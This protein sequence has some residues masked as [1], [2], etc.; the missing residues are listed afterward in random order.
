MQCSQLETD[1]PHITQVD[2]WET[3]MQYDATLH[4]HYS[5]PSALSPT[6]FIQPT[7]TTQISQI[8]AFLSQAQCN[9]AVKADRHTL[10]VGANAIHNGITIRSATKESDYTQYQ[11]PDG[12]RRSRC[13]VGSSIHDARKPRMLRARA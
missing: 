4:S 11:D 6:C 7:N 5:L 12:F 13:K 10:F 9:S 2:Q 3:S 1:L 8:I